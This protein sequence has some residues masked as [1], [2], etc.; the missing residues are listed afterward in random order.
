MGGEPLRAQVA[1]TAHEVEVLAHGGEILGAQPW[2]GQPRDHR[3]ER[4]PHLVELLEVRRRKLGNAHPQP[5]MR[6]EQPL[7]LQ[8]PQRVAD[9]HAADLELLGEPL[10]RQPLAGSQAPGEHVVPQAGGDLLGQGPRFELL[11]S[12]NDVVYGTRYA[13]RERSASPGGGVT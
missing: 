6:H 13:G 5:R 12:G 1:R 7:R 3:L 8:L 9:R 4:E 2:R 10:L 11:R